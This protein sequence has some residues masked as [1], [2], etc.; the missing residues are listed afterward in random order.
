MFSP[1]GFK[2]NLSLLDLFIFSRG[3][4]QMEATLNALAASNSSVQINSF[5]SNDALPQLVVTPRLAK[6]EKAVE[7][8]EETEEE[9]EE[10]GEEKKE[11]AK[12]PQE[13]KDEKEEK[14]EEAMGN[15][16]PH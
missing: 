12:Q 2:G 11:E 5:G 9:K 4:D 8:K 1:V 15:G 10:K 7:K 16:M 3:L 13:K 14:E 6:E